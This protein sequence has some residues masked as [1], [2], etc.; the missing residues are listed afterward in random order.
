MSGR[1]GLQNAQPFAKGG[2]LGDFHERRAASS[3]SESLSVLHLAGTVFLTFSCREYTIRVR[4]VSRSEA[5]S[6]GK[7][8]TPRPVD[9]LRQKL[10]VSMLKARAFRWLLRLTGRT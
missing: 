10:D 9:D 7:L 2:K 8:H 5:A 6:I 4:G 3:S 1:T